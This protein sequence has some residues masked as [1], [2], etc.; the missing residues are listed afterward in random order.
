MIKITVNQLII[1]ALSCLALV[2][3]EKQRKT[4]S[5]QMILSRVN[6]CLR[7]L[8]YW[9]NERT[10]LGHQTLFGN[11]L[12]VTQVLFKLDDN[13]HLNSVMPRSFLP[14]KWHMCSCVFPCL[15]KINGNHGCID[16]ASTIFKR[17]SLCMDE[18][19]TS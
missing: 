16:D 12:N 19:L 9:H 2:L 13:I 3:C 6:G 17:H 4:I 5:R 1:L 8:R 14:G 18:T 10:H 7:N 11:H 15:H